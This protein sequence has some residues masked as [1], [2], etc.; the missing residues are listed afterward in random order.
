[1][2]ES[3][4]NN[5]DAVAVRKKNKKMVEDVSQLRELN[6]KIVNENEQLRK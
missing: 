4:E 5:N 2:E 6:Q 1:M 3:H